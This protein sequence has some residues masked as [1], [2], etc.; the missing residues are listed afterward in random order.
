MDIRL[1]T[2]REFPETEEF[3]D[4]VNTNISMANPISCMVQIA[5]NLFR[6]DSPKSINV[7][8]STEIDSNQNK[9]SSCVGESRCI[10][11]KK[12]IAAVLTKNP[13]RNIENEVDAST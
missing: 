12:K 2:S 9:A 5:T 3:S 7:L 4:L 1:C 11:L 10:I 13:L 6:S 8:H